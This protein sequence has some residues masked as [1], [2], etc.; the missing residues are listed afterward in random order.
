MRTNKARQADEILQQSIK[1]G[2]RTLDALKVLTQI[3]LALGEWD[4]A[5]RLAQELKK[6]EGEEALSE[7][8]MRNNFV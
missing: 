8:V 4:E 5:E 6:V 1:K 2:N 7:Q 3:K